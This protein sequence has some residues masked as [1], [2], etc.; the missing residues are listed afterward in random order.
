MFANFN[1]KTTKAIVMNIVIRCSKQAMVH[2]IH[3]T[4]TPSANGGVDVPISKTALDM[5]K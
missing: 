4:A 5:R 3:H 2:V 1:I